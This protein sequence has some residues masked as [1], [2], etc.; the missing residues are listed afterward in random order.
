MHHDI[1]HLHGDGPLP[2]PWVSNGAAE[3]EDD[4]VGDGGGS[5]HGKAGEAAV[6]GEGGEHDVDDDT[7]DALPLRT[8]RKI[9]DARTRRRGQCTQRSLTAQDLFLHP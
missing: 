4:G 1:D 2:T 5:H 9:R 3:G 6:D 8:S 7:G